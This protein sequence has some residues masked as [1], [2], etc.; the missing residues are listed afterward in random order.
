M[1]RNQQYRDNYAC[2]DDIDVNIDLAEEIENETQNENWF[3]L[4]IYLN[5]I[6]M[7]MRMEKWMMR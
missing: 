5:L 2:C 1:K 7:T 6:Y 4:T 3:C